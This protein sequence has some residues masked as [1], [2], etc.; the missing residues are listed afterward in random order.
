MAFNGLAAILPPFSQT[1]TET[2]KA[3]SDLVNLPAHGL[4]SQDEETVLDMESD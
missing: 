2:H 1:Q 3:Q 4:I